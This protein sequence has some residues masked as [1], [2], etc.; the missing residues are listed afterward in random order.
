MK[1]LLVIDDNAADRELVR[2]ALGKAFVVDEASTADEGLRKLQDGKHHVVL[3]DLVLHPPID[4]ERMIKHLRAASPTSAVVVFSGASDP[5]QLGLAIQSDPDAYV[6][7]P[8]GLISADYTAQLLELA[9]M[10]RMA[11]KRG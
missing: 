1:T 6:K 9:I 5:R 11:G 2:I 10:H 7:K 4:P 8:T 3:L